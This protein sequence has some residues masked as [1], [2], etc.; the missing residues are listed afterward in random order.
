VVDG[1]I[2]WMVSAPGPWSIGWAAMAVELWLGA[3]WFRLRP[4]EELAAGVGGCACWYPALRLSEIAG[5]RWSVAVVALLV[6]S[7]VAVL[8]ILRR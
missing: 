1:L 6:A 8:W 3:V 4:V 5:G 7:V 2:A